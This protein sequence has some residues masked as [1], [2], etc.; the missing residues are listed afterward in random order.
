MPT[1]AVEVHPAPLQGANDELT[2]DAAP[3]PLRLLDELKCL[4]GERSRRAA[5]LLGRAVARGSS[6]AI[7]RGLAFN[8]VISVFGCVWLQWRGDNLRNPLAADT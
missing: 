1:M 5:R 8:S 6:A 2:V 3:V 4:S 7:R